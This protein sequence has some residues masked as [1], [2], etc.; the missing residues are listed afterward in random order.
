MVTCV[1]VTDPTRPNTATTIITVMILGA[2][3]RWPR[4][5]WPTRP[6]TAIT[7]ALIGTSTPTHLTTFTQVSDEN[8]LVPIFISIPIFVSHFQS[9]FSAGPLCYSHSFLFILRVNLPTM[10]M[11]DNL[12]KWYEGLYTIKGFSGVAEAKLHKYKNTKKYIY[13]QIQRD[14]LNWDG[15]SWKVNGERSGG[16][17]PAL[18]QAQALWHNFRRRKMFRIA[19]LHCCMY[20]ERLL[21][22]P[23]FSNMTCKN[24]CCQQR[25][26]Q[27]SAL[28]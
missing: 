21:I 28:P 10:A 25:L 13:T 1:L 27:F 26:F 14:G 5:W 22:I 11:R 17:R 2:Q 9:R 12:A 3:V 18:A 19:K 20:R 15:G 16:G 24:W 8:S 4:W 6:T 23:L 7:I